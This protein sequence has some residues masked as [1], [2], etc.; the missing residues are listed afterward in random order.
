MRANVALGAAIGCAVVAIA[1]VAVDMQFDT[2]LTV[3]TN[4]DGT[5]EEVS[6]GFRSPRGESTGCG[7]TELRIV[8]HHEGPFK[9]SMPVR[10]WYWSQSGGEVLAAD[11]TVNVAAGGTAT[12]PFTVPSS[13]FEFQDNAANAQVYVNIEA[14]DIYRNVCSQMEASP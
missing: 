8:I 5:W 13:A 6:D 11:E 12:V 7:T 1:I 10:A 3:E 4:R 14:G 2:T 9:A